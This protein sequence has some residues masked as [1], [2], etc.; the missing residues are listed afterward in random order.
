MRRLVPVVV[1]LTLAA[2]D[3]QQL[4]EQAGQGVALKEGL[5]AAE[6][7]GRPPALTPEAVDE[8][9]ELLAV[10]ARPPARAM[11]RLG[12]LRQTLEASFLL[13]ADG[14]REVALDEKLELRHDAKGQ[15]ALRHDNTSWS[16]EDREA[17]GGRACWWVDGRFYTA[18]A[19]GPAT[20]VPV[21][22]YEQERC[23]ESATEP[24]V[25]LLRLLGGHLVTSP[26]VP[27]EV[28]GRKALRI[29]LTRDGVAQ[30]P[31]SQVPL[32]WPPGDAGVES[33][34]I[35]GPRPPLVELHARPREMKGEVILDVET[36]AVLAGEIQGALVVRKANRDATLQLRAKLVAE[37]LDVAITPPE[38]ARV[39]G[40][41][42]RVFED[43]RALL[44]EVFKKREK[45]QLPKPGDAPPLR[46]GATEDDVVPPEGEGEAGAPDDGDPPA[47][48]TPR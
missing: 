31:T 40:P 1:A 46:L 42:Q 7:A 15:Y 9:A 37:P 5:E 38:G 32:A 47:E 36:G 20:E 41:R 8:R 18:R 17:R 39:Y 22:A 3:L 16:A 27:T 11:P 19:Q 26:G 12:A 4:Q 33:A 43:R 2:C 48:G 25:G 29:A 44:G 30:P 23:L 13:E 14:E 35:Y 24:F 10:L 45:V 34:A 6:K 21:R 28:A